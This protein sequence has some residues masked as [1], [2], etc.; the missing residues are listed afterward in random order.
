MG[1]REDYAPKFVLAVIRS[2]LTAEEH[3]GLTSGAGVDVNIEDV[4][5]AK[6]GTLSF[7]GRRVI[8]YIRDVSVF[9]DRSGLPRYHL[10]SCST[11]QEAKMHGR[12]GRR[13][14]VS[15]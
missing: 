12:F 6:D 8:L 7:K 10:A 3:E 15:T 9:G 5:I 13:Y 1:I 4:E 11:L 14:V 2:R